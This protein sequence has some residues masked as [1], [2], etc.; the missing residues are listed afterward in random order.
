[1]HLHIVI[2]D[3]FWP[4]SD[5]HELY[6]DLRL[7]ALELLLARG[8]RSV[9]P[10]GGYERWIAA[11]FGVHGDDVP[12]APYRLLGEGID[13]GASRWLCADPVHLEAG[14]DSVSLSEAA[15]LDI[16]GTEAAALVDALNGHFSG[17]GIQLVAPAPARW[18]TRLADDAELGDDGLI[19]TALESAHGP[20]GDE[21]LPRGR[22]GAR[23]R[24]LLTEAQMLMHEHPV[25]RAREARGAPMVNG[26][27]VWG[28]G[29]RGALA[30]RRRE[31]WHADDALTRGLARAADAFSACAPEA[32]LKEGLLREGIRWFVLGGARER[33][34]QGDAAGWRSALAR[35]ESDW[36]AP[37]ASLLKHGDIG[38]ASIHAVSPHGTLSVETT[39]SDLRHLWHRPRPLVTYLAASA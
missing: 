8:R 4:R 11:Q 16:D 15:F 22:A 14:M 19:T 18:Y 38:M 12:V 26:I 24:A 39:R 37:T 36:F 10:L 6:R 2:P 7:P 25:N 1:M 34:K 29:A 3:L 33:V 17:E 31:R 9:S 13:P 27:W 23:W 5:E 20:I 35:L 32:L 30:S 21:T 28:G